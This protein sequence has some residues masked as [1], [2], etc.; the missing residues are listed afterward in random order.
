MFVDIVP[1]VPVELASAS[2]CFH[3]ID[4]SFEKTGPNHSVLVLPVWHPVIKELQELE[5]TAL[6]EAKLGS[7]SEVTDFNREIYELAE[8]SDA[9]I[10]QRIDAEVY[11]LAH[12]A[13][14]DDFGDRD[15]D[16]GY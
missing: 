13:D 5:E 8:Q 3:R 10:Q 14:D 12:L 11:S 4:F 7:R 6:I 1:F 2:A 9:L 16:E 15:G